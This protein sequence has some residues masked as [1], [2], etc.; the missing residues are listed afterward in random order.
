MQEEKTGFLEQY[1]IA[2]SRPSQYH[3]TLMKN[4]RSAL[5]KYLV[6]LCLFLTFL[7]TVIPFAAW[8]VS[9]GGMK[10]LILRG[11]PSFSLKD[12]VFQ[13][14]EPLDFTLGNSTHIKVDSK[15]KEFTSQDIDSDYIQEFLISRTNIL[16]SADYSVR[17]IKLSDMKSFTL[18]NQSLVDFLPFIRA[19]IGLTMLITVLVKIVE[20]LFV[21]AFFALFCRGSVRN[22]EGKMV[23]MK[24]AFVIAIYAKTLFAIINSIDAALGGI[25]PATLLIIA[26]VFVTMMYI[27]RA[28][29][30]ILGV[31]SKWKFRE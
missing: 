21:A 20:Y 11:I 16:V 27:S 7:D 8:D 1:Y 24:E 25:L 29:M 23:S 12:G 22:D 4:S 2:C 15:E 6:V 17:E 5:V 26:N 28:E 10:N 19:T 31:D 18:D 9:V 13:S 14:E 30:K 3:K